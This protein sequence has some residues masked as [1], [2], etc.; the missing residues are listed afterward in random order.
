MLAADTQTV[1]DLNARA[2]AYR[3]RPDRSPPDGVGI[4]DGTTAGV[5]DV[6]VTRLN[7]R[8]L[9]TGRGWVKN[10]DDWI[11]RQFAMTVP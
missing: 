2:R 10:G 9:T 8:A 1:A 6:I 11:V 5:G 3:H 4:A 7:Q